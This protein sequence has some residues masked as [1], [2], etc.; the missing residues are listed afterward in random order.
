MRNILADSSFCSRNSVVIKVFYVKKGQP[1]DMVFPLSKEN[2]RGRFVN[3]VL[4]LSGQDIFAC[5]QCG[6]C[7]ALCPSLERMDLLPNQLVRMV[8]FGRKEVLR[9]KTIWICSSCFSC[10]VECPKGIDI[11]SLAEALR[12][13]QLRLNVDHLDLKKIS[14]E[15]LEELPPIALVG[16]ARKFTA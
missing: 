10:A 15:D 2:I 5:Y 14:T 6:K 13:M 8:Q 4:E 12:L 11:A 16:G 9:S 1:I 7:S 3:K